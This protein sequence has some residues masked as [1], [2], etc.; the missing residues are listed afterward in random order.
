MLAMS[1]NFNGQ[2]LTLTPSN[3][4]IKVRRL[5]YRFPCDL[6]IRDRRATKMNNG[7][8]ILSLK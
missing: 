1:F 2:V 5:L 4:I 7:W 8:I 3:Y 6:L